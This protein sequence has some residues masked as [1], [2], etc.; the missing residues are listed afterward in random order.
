MVSI[1]DHGHIVYVKFKTP[2]LNTVVCAPDRNSDV[3]GQASQGYQLIDGFPIALLVP[4][5][6]PLRNVSDVI[7]GRILERYAIGIEVAA[8]SRGRDVKSGDASDAHDVS[9]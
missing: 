5:S 3:G 4:G 8:H 2:G 1:G 7:A 9:I 6:C